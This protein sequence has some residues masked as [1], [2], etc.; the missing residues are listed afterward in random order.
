MEETQTEVYI[1]QFMSVNPFFDG[2]TSWLV[3]FGRLSSCE[4]SGTMV[5]FIEKNGRYDIPPRPD[6]FQLPFRVLNYFSALYTQI[7]SE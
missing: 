4:G 3:L 2:D 5:Q 7:T 6:L 1:R